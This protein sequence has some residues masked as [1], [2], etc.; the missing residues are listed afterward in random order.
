MKTLLLIA[1]VIAI[2]GLITS[3]VILFNLIFT[4]NEKNFNYYR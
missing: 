1:F 3:L 2:V 4:K